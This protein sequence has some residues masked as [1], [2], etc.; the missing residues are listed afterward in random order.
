MGM[1]SMLV[2]ELMEGLVSKCGV[3]VERFGR[4]ASASGVPHSCA[5]SAH[6]WATREV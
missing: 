6:E 5:K 3:V 2:L 1:R 4:C